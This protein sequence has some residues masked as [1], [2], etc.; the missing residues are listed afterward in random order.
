MANIVKYV[1]KLDRHIEL[2]GS[3]ARTASPD[4]VELRGIPQGTRGLIVVLNATVKGD[5]PSVTMKIQ[6]VDA[7]TGATWDIISATALTDIG[8]RVLRVG[9]IAT[10]SNVA[11]NDLVPSAV[12]VTCTA[13]SADSLTYS[14]TAQL[15]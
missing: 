1:T 12:R 9:N 5:S 14:V 8:T 2:L 3:A 13:N 4:T 7:I 6:G 10:A 11:A 15:V